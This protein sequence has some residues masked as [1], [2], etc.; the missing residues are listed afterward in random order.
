[1]LRDA[2]IF[3]VKSFGVSSSAVQAMQTLDA[4]GIHATIRPMKAPGQVDNP[5]RRFTVFVLSADAEG[6]QHVL[7]APANTSAIRF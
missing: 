2:R 1:V 7:A 6:A 3:Q 4:Q 5:E